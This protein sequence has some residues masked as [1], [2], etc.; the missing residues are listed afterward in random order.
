MD[1][2][3][4]GLYWSP[5]YCRKKWCQ[6]QGSKRRHECFLFVNWLWIN[7][8]CHFIANFKSTVNIDRCIET[9]SNMICDTLPQL[10]IW[11]LIEYWLRQTF[12][13][14]KLWPVFMTPKLYTVLSCCSRTA[15]ERRGSGTDK[16]A[17]L[18]V[19]EFIAPLYHFLSPLLV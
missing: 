6:I 11:V 7:K 2:T 4:A 17:K 5:C 14:Q 1:T 12:T 9:T 10:H 16:P 13:T 3:I 15:G 8:A 19:V 18:P